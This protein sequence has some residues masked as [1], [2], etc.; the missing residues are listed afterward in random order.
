MKAIK[1][2]VSSPRVIS[3]TLTGFIGCCSSLMINNI[4]ISPVVI[5]ICSTIIGILWGIIITSN[6]VNNILQSHI[7]TLILL[8]ISTFCFCILS[9]GSLFGMIT[10]SLMISKPISILQLMKPPNGGGF[11]FFVLFNTLMELI[12]FPLLVNRLYNHSI[13]IN[14][15]LL[16]SSSIYYTSRAWTYIYFAPVIVNTF[17]P[18]ASKEIITLDTILE[19]QLIQW[20]Q[21]SW[22]RCFAD[23]FSSFILLVVISEYSSNPKPIKKLK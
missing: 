22:I 9:G 6:H 10:Y 14:R 2:M 12:L 15:M 16:T 11:L 23:C 1:S 18:I 7:R 8:W 5:C 21:L 4:N 19:S 17:I 13:N 20:I 3:I